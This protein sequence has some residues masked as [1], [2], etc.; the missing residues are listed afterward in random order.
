MNDIDAYAAILLGEMPLID[1]RAPIE[2]ARGSFPNAVNLPL[3]SDEERAEVGTCYKQQGQASAI[4]LGHQLVSEDVKENRVAQWQNFAAQHPDGALFCFR[5][6][7]RS[8][9][10]QQWLSDV[11]VEYPRI[12][13]GYKAMRRWLIDSLE[14]LCSD[15][16]LVIIG[17]RTG[18][19]KTDLINEGC[20]GGAIPG[21]VDLEGLAHHRGSAFGKRPG[22]QPTQINFE[23]A[24]AIALLKAG[25]THDGTLVLEDES[26]LIGRCALPLA[27]QAAMKA[28]PIML[29]ES[30]LEA[31]VA[32]SF[33]NYIL[34][35]LRTLQ[36]QMDSATEA[37]DVFAQGLRDSMDGINRRLGDV[38]HKILRTQLESALSNH[39]Q[40]DASEHLIWIESLLKD[41]YDPMYDYQLSKRQD[42]V[43]FRGDREQIASR[44]C[45]LT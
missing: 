5:G 29:L 37:F 17:G 24:L 9:I 41:Y 14:Q 38:R 20:G 44:L 1:T 11:S 8:A 7:M 3:M 35:N 23:N 28:A 4:A 19:A 21:S 10:S 18:C 36:Q 45:T 43:V 6:G 27:L 25:Q 39:L 16:Q 31:R 42:L 34:D 40:G 13:G 32:H 33:D 2:F 30:S 26:R 15:R 22:G 12:T